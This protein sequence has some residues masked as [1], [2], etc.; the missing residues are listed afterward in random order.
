MNFIRTM[1]IA[2]ALCMSG[3]FVNAQDMI[4][5]NNISLSS[6]IM[7][8]EALWAM[9]RIG[10][11]SASPNGKQI[12]YQVGYYS[13]EK[14]K[15]HQMLFL[16]NADGSNAVQLTNDAKSETDAAWIKGGTKIAFLREGEIWTMDADGGNRV[17]LSNTE[18]CI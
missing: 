18:G 14:N 17:K 7:T 5:K 8:P 10:G 1:T 3:S 4:A 15:G 12:V 13:V 9:G 16:M 11:Y 6:D 2:A